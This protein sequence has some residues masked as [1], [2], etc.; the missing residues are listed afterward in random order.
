MKKPD[1]G[2]NTSGGSD[3]I[4]PGEPIVPLPKKPWM[5]SFFNKSS[6]AAGDDAPKGPRWKEG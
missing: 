5:D 1:E 4:P 3:R 6:K 2:L